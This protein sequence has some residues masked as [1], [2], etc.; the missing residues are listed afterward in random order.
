[1]IAALDNEIV[2]KMAFQNK[3]VFTQFVKDILGID[4]EGVIETEKRFKSKHSNIDFRLDIF[5]ES[6]DKRVII[7]IQRIAFDHH[8]DRFLG[9]FLNTITEQQQSSK[10]YEIHKTVYSIVILTTPYRV[11][12]KTGRPIA[13]EYLMQQ[14]DPENLKKEKINIYGHTQV[15]LNP[16][17][18]KSTTPK[19]I[20]EWLDLINGSIKDPKN[21]KAPPENIGIKTA[22]KIINEEKFD[23][24][25]WHKIKIAN[26][27]RNTLLV[28]EEKKFREGKIK[29]EKIG[30][31]KGEKIGIQKGEKIGIQKEKIKGIIK[32][33]KRGRLT[34]D[35][36]A[37]DFDV[38]LE[39][40]MQIKTEKKL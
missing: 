6:N 26:E 7:E 3:I 17:Y 24:D 10:E 35:E 15:F 20:K 31:Q 16:Y 8:F 11:D 22:V 9:T 21:Y 30:I 12:D 28:I 32:A 5:A 19:S 23:S 29:G 33:L 14:L 27:T 1:M 2:F 37:E 34:L 38:S 39:F 40:V 18:V 4:F 36:I 13:E 25:T